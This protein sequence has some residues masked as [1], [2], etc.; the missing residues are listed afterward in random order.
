[1][2]IVLPARVGP[3][4][5]GQGYQG[6]APS[7]GAQTTLRHSGSSGMLQQQSA[8][9]IPTLRSPLS[10]ATAPALCCLLRKHCLALSSARMQPCPFRAGRANNGFTDFD[11]Y[12]QQTVQQSNGSF[13]P[14]T[15]SHQQMYT[16]QRQQQPSDVCYSQQGMSQQSM[17]GNMGGFSSSQ[18]TQY[19]SLDSQQQSMG[20][21]QYMQNYSQMLGGDASQAST[22][23]NIGSSMGMSM[24]MSSQGF[25]SQDNLQSDYNE[26]LGNDMSQVMDFMV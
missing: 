25:V 12:I 9:R 24:P 21:S 6:L 1:M 18:G 23:T 26:V 5:R 11:N 16:T 8:P 2:R 19:Y 13:I 17:D 14:Q 4:A 3:A 20:G 15:V 10:S 22:M 7:G